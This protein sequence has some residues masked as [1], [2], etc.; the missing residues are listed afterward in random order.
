MGLTEKMLD[1]HTAFYAFL[2]G[3]FSSRTFFTQ[4]TSSPNSDVSIYECHR[5]RLSLILC[6]LSP[7][8]GSPPQE[9]LFTAQDGS[10]RS[11]AWLLLTCASANSEGFLRTVA[12]LIP[13]HRGCNHCS[14]F[15]PVSILKAMGCWASAAY[16]SG[17]ICYPSLGYLGPDFHAIFVVQ[18]AM[19]STHPDDID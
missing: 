7:L 5:V 19:C 18:E 4:I 6:I 12:Y 17:S 8:P 9:L 11:R 2:M 13:A 3:E 10:P 16:D 1:I 14:C 15:S